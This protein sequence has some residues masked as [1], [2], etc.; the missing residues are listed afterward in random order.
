MNNL[1][2]EEKWEKPDKKKILEKIFNLHKMYEDGLLGGEFMP[3]DANPGLDKDCSDNY[4]YFTLP[5]ALNYQRNSYKLWPAA[6]NAYADINCRKIFNPNEVNKMSLSELKE[7]LVHYKIALQPN[8]HVE[9]WKTICD[10]IV[11]YY[12]GDIRNLFKETKGDIKI[13]KEI[14]QVQR[15]KEFPYLSGNK[16]CNYWLYVM[17]NYT[18]ANLMNRNFINVAPDTHVI[19]STFRLGLINP[20]ERENTKL[21]DIVSDIWYEILKDT[22]LSPIDIHTPLWLWSRAGFP[23]ITKK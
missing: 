6:T 10:T 9:I 2:E 21:Q 19:Q 3:E 17:G 20:I 7:C 5:M 8:K 15:K 13:I 16:I 11:K 4:H 1:F 12:E 22:N 18:S 14:V 23:T